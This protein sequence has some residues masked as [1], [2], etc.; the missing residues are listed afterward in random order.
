MRRHI[1]RTKTQ[2][3]K[4]STIRYS[5]SFSFFYLSFF[6]IMQANR[7]RNFTAPRLLKEKETARDSDSDGD[8]IPF[9]ELKKK[10]RTESRGVTVKKTTFRLVWDRQRMQ[11][12]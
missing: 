10:V 3:N 7:R 8:N 6:Y 12:H 1:A 4:G 5:C 11:H 9:S 2:N